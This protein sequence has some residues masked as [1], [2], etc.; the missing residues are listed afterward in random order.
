MSDTIIARAVVCFHDDGQGID[1]LGDNGRTYR[2]RQLSPGVMTVAINGDPI[3]TVGITRSIVDGSVR[4]V[5]WASAF[6]AERGSGTTVLA[7]AL[8]L[9]EAYRARVP[10][11][12]SP[13]A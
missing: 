13:Q 6:D 2:V 3:G 8:G 11:P 4:N 1:V 10:D 5:T 9:I 12:D 7:A